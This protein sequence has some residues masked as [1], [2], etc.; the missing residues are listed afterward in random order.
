MGEDYDQINMDY[1][2]ACSELPRNMESNIA[3]MQKA[4]SADE[5]RKG[6]F[7]R[8]LESCKLLYAGKN[9]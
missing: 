9:I 5:R 6:K 4:I 3:S 8:R 7:L 1:K 2:Q